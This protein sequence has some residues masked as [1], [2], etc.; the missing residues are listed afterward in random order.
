MKCSFFFSKDNDEYELLSRL[1]LCESENER[2][3]QQLEAFANERQQTESVPT[4]TDEDDD[5]NSTV[6]YVSV[7]EYSLLY[8]YVTR[9][10]SGT[11]KLRINSFQL[12]T[13]DGSQSGI[14]ICATSV[15][16]QLW[17]SRINMIVHN[18]TTRTIT[19][20][21]QTLLPSE[22][23][24]YATWTH[25]RV[26]NFTQNRLPEWKPIFLVLKGSDLYIFD[27]NKSAPLCAYDF[28]CCSRV[29]P[30]IEV[31]IEIVSAKYLRD[32]RRH[33]FK[34]ILSNDLKIKCHYLNFETK[35]EL[36]DCLSNWQRSLYMSVYAL[37]N[38]A[39]GC[40]YQGQICRLMI[41]IY[42]GFEMYNNE[43]NII[44]W[45][46]AFE[47]LQ[48]SSD[49]GR[50]KIYFEFKRHSIS[51]ENEPTINIEVQCQHLRILIHVINAFLTVKLIGKKDDTIS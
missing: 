7:Q 31:L 9:Y 24:L 37:K 15:Q 23:V 45:S 33:C 11:D 35:N 46:F 18:L 36:D 28:I 30:I 42:K 38:R 5:V 39:F 13:L 16:Q 2:C 22:Q 43:T 40:I 41:D 49:N 4:L 6:D 48:S 25:E 20:L 44:L 47:Q 10:I 51:N 32:D 50:D 29:Y 14:I 21:N 17:I 12:H 26:T 19:E 8:A 3:R 1:L 27:D 34:L